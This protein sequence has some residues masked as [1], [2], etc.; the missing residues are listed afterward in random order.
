MESIGILEKLIRHGRFYVFK[1]TT[2][3]IFSSKTVEPSLW[4]TMSVSDQI[5][6]VSHKY[7]RDTKT[8]DVGGFVRRQ[9]K[10]R[11]LVLSQ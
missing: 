7:L 8:N 10:G 1:L 5:C 11:K 2:V 6:I 4:L 3:P 9:L